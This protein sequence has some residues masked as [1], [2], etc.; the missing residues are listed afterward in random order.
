VEV[1]RFDLWVILVVSTA[2]PEEELRAW[3]HGRASRHP[4]MA[5]VRGAVR[6]PLL[7][8]ATVA[9]PCLGPVEGMAGEDERGSDLGRRS[10]IC[11]VGKPS[12]GRGKQ[13]SGRHRAGKKV[14]KPRTDPGGTDR[15]V[16]V[17]RREARTMGADED[18]DRE[19]HAEG[20]ADYGP[21]RQATD[22]ETGVPGVGHYRDRDPHPG[23]GADLGH[24]HEAIEE[25]AI[26]EES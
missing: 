26:D 20:G 11:L 5:Q 7:T 23:G 6:R 21:E 12:E 15:T 2:G 4:A 25:E 8:V 18:R 16:V 22:E 14:P 19:R 9:D 10:T 13:G 1:T 3:K 17:S 24:V